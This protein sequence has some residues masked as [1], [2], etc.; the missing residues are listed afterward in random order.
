MKQDLQALGVD[1][2]AVSAT[3]GLAVHSPID[4]AKIG[5]VAVDEA[6][7]I[8]A[9]V[10]LGRGA[11]QLTDVAKLDCNVVNDSTLGGHLTW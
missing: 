2:S 11:P 5:S 7:S 4:G 6:A 9:K 10:T 8:N 3:G 1:P